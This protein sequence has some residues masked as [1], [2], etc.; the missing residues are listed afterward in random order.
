VNGVPVADAG[1][2]GVT[3]A[4][5]PFVLDGSG[6]FDP[7]GD[8]LTY[9][10]SLDVPAGS[11]AVLDD[12]SLESPSFTPDIVGAYR[13]SLVVSDQFAVSVAD[14]VVVTVSRP[15]QAPV[16]DAGQAQTVSVGDSVLLD[17]AGSFDPDGDVI[18]YLWTFFDVP[19]GAS[20][21]LDDPTSANPSFIADVAGVYSVSLVVSDGLLD[22][23]TEFV[24]VGFCD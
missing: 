5:L 17:G 2:D 12:A 20:V 19:V 24:E 6:S 23:A 18:T 4:D 11:V 9:A 1:A 14:E 21:A 7:D 10:W 8:P 13:A 3:V 22:S 15:N 16:A